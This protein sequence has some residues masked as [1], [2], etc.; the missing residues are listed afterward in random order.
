MPLPQSLCSAH[1]FTHI[2]SRPHIT[3]KVSLQPTDVSKILS[4]SPV[5]HTKKAIGLGKVW[6]WGKAGK[7]KQQWASPGGWKKILPFKGNWKE[8]IMKPRTDYIERAMFKMDNDMSLWT[9]KRKRWV[10]RLE[11]IEI[12]KH[13][14]GRTTLISTAIILA[15]K[16]QA[17]FF[18]EY[19]I[20]EHLLLEQY[21]TFTAFKF[22]FIITQKFIDHSSQKNIK[23]Q[24]HIC[25]KWV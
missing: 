3:P 19:K 18:A 12:K 9:W 4:A 17:I 24:Y 7:M 5:Y 8:R 23:P 1:V 20:G 10:E 6:Q 13:Q 11:N 15:Y 16:S 14:N 2:I 22:C 25:L 21:W